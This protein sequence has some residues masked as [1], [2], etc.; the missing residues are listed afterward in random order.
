M[1]VKTKSAARGRRHTRLRIGAEH[2]PGLRA[3]GPRH[4]AFFDDYFF[5]FAGE[6]YRP[7]DV[8]REGLAL[9]DDDAAAQGLGAFEG[10][11]DSRLVLLTTAASERIDRACFR[12]DDVILLGRMLTKG[13]KMRIAQCNNVYIF[14][15]MGLAL[16]ATQARRVTDRMFLAAAR[17]LAEQSPALADSSAP[18]LPPLTD[19]RRAAIEIAFVAAEQAQREGLSPGTSPESLRN[20]IISS[21]WAPRYASY[22]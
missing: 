22:L 12:E 14:P 1:A 10:Q 2:R 20:T 9:A 17:A 21:Q 18:L 3:V 13:R 5:V 11:L 19:L 8:E 16:L 7:L 15:A 6:L 4:A